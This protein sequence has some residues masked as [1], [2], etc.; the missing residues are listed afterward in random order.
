MSRTAVCYAM[1]ESGHSVTLTPDAYEWLAR[2]NARRAAG[3]RPPVD[4]D[5]EWILPRC[6]QCG[7]YFAKQKG[8]GQRRAFC[9]NPCRQRAYRA[10]QAVTP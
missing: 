3:G 2:L 6:G 4:A 5:I 8:P 1:R 10:R 7:V 9:S